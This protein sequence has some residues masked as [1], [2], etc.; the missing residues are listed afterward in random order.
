MEAAQNALESA[1][2]EAKCNI[3]NGVGI[4]SVVVYCASVVVV[5]YY[6]LFCRDNS[7]ATL[8]S[9]NTTYHHCV[10][11]SIFDCLTYEWWMILYPTITSNHP[12]VKVKLMGRSSGYIA[13]FATLA[14]GEVV[15]T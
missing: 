13:A 5:S 4:V 8:P 15:I 9:E 6:C 2:T 14:S 11:S 10:F 12:S 1:V 7:H 3:P